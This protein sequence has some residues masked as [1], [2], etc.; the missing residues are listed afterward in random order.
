M[1]VLQPCI[2]FLYHQVF[3]GMAVVGTTPHQLFAVQQVVGYTDIEIVELRRLHQP[4]LHDLSECGDA[5][6]HQGILEDVEVGVYCGGTHSAILCYIGVV[7]NLAVGQCRHFQKALEGVE[8]THQGFF[9]YL[10]FQVN[11][12]ISG[13]ESRRVLGK[14]VRRK[15]SE[16]DGP[17]DIKLRYLGAD[18]WIEIYGEGSSSES[19][20]TL[21]FQLPGAG[22]T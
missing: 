13:Q 15:H 2:D 19:V 10:F 3:K 21:A 1:C 20:V 12:Y 17:I 6:P 5:I 4:P 16:S 14:I 11:V 9:F 8:V 18:E 7:Y 22:A